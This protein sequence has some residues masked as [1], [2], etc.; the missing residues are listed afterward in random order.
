MSPPSTMN[1]CHP[2]FREDNRIQEITSIEDLTFLAS[3]I[4]DSDELYHFD[5]FLNALV[6]WNEQLEAKHITQ[7]TPV[8]QRA[9]KLLINGGS[10]RNG[11]SDSMMAT[12]LIDY[13]KLL[14]KRF[15][16]EAKELSTLHEKMVQKR[17]TSERS[18]EISQSAENNHPPEE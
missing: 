8:L 14:I 10:S 13:A 7:W 12:F 9:Y 5:L 1:R 6:E 16:I 3:Q 11:I 17:R 18:V 2:S 15:P 4:L